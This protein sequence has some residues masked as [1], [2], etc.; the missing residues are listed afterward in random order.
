MH[1]KEISHAVECLPYPIAVSILKAVP[2][3]STRSKYFSLVPLWRVVLFVQIAV[4]SQEFWPNID[5]STFVSN[6]HQ[7]AMGW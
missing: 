5:L 3:F 2:A 1:V 7:L 6:R 4:L